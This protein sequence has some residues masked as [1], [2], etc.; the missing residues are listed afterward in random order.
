MEVCGRRKSRA[1]VGQNKGAGW[2][3]VVWHCGLLI[4]GVVVGSNG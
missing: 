3:G 2:A 4:T 1:G